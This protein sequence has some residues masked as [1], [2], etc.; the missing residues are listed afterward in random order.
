MALRFVGVV[1]AL[2]LVWLAQAVY[3]DY[4]HC[5][6]TCDPNMWFSCGGIFSCD[7]LLLAILWPIVGAIIAG[8]LVVLPARTALASA[9]EFAA[10]TAFEMAVFLSG[11]FVF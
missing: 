8:F 2:L 9:L 3:T 5:D 7:Y 4:I 10:L 11:V 6:D 1:V